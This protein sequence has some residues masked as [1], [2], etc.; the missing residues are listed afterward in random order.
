MMFERTWP[1]RRTTAAAV[2][3]QDDS[4]A[5]SSSPLRS[6]NEAD[7]AESGVE[8]ET[9]F[10]TTYHTENNGR[11]RHCGL[12]CQTTPRRIL[13]RNGAIRPV[14]PQSR[15]TGGLAPCR[16]KHIVLWRNILRSVA[17]QTREWRILRWIEAFD[18]LCSVDL[19]NSD[20]RD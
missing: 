1:S 18:S 7:S 8:L 15:L 4:M 16:Y 20:D 14:A 10:T 19:V 11:Q 17:C 9:A 13:K 12:D 2:S 5:S 6:G 3:S